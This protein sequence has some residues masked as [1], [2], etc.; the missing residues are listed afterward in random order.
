MAVYRATARRRWEEDQLELTRRRDHA[1]QVARQATML[2]KEQFGAKRVVAFGSLVHGQWFSRTS[3][4]D[5]A[6]WGLRADDYFLA[7]AKLQDLSG[8]FKVD[9]IDMERCRPVLRDAIAKEGRV[10]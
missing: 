2:L 3:D 1:W 6:A 4:I 10:L 8:E 9:L 7:V 5:L